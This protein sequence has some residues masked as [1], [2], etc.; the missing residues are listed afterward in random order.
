MTAA[1]YTYG[2]MK[3]RLL[4]HAQ[5]ASAALANPFE[6]VKAAFPLPKGRCVRVY[7]GGED[8]P[9]G[10]P[11]RGSRSMG[12]ELIGKAT[13]I[14]AFW[15]VTSLDEELAELIDTEAEAFGHALRTAI[16]GDSSLDGAADNTVLGDATPDFAVV[17]NTRY[18][19]ME[20]RAV[21]AYIEYGIA[22]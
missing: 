22:R 20:W 3:A 18:V 6:D 7:Y 11:E 10:F 8:D 2:P 17:G 13:L 5:T 4:V 15:P 9:P 19:V 16:D 21:S 14:A 1:T 12:Y